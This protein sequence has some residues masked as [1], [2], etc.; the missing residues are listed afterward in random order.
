[1][2]DLHIFGDDYQTLIARHIR[3]WQMVFSLDGIV[4]GY[5]VERPV[6][7]GERDIVCEAAY[8][9]IHREFGGK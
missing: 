4:G 3:L 7:I 6:K 5:H 2:E 9:S 1:M 8:K